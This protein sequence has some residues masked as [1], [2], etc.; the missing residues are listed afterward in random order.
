MKESYAV[1]DMG[2]L[3]TPNVPAGG[4]YWPEPL[5]GIAASYCIV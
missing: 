3:L 5:R 4:V 1:A 2:V